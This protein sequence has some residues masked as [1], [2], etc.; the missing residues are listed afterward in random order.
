MR[1]KKDVIGKLKHVYV[2]YYIYKIMLLLFAVA[3]YVNTR[4]VL[5]FYFQRGP[6]KTSK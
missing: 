6:R 5:I 3:L 2:R 1:L 4:V